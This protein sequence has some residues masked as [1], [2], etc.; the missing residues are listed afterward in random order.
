MNIEGG[1]W[2]GL[3]IPRKFETRLG[4]TWVH[5]IFFFFFSASAVSVDICIIVVFSSSPEKKIIF[6]NFG[7]G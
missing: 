6:V 5:L 4:F 1:S 3:G 2:S 7:K